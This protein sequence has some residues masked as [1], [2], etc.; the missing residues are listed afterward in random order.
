MAQH[1]VQVDS[2]YREDNDNK[3]DIDEETQLLGLIERYWLMDNVDGLLPHFYLYEQIKTHDMAEGPYVVVYYNDEKR[4]PLG[5]GYGAV[6]I[7]ANMTIEF[8]TLTRSQ[9]FKMK[10]EIFR[11]LEY[12]RKEPFLEYNLILNH[13]G[14]RIDAAPGSFAYTIDIALVILVKRINNTQ[15]D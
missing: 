6:T 15:W 13:G 7:H 5:L 1:C 8:R 14:R 12:I 3:Y 2:Q 9:L 10:E 11:I 4:D